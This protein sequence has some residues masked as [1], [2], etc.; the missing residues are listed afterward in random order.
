[1]KNIILILSI[2]CLFAGCKKDKNEGVNLKQDEQTVIGAW[3]LTKVEGGF[4]PTN[5]FTNEIKWTFSNDNTISVVIEEGTLMQSNNIPFT[6]EG[7]YSY[8]QNDST[9]VLANDYNYYYELSNNNL[10]LKSS[11]QGMTDDGTVITFV[12]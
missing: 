5:N 3:Y 4:S 12:K 9:I 1:M 11:K 7:V 6:N 2:A 10:I 8:S